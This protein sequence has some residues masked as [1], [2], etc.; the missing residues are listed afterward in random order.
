ML[1]F[2]STGKA[3]SILL[4]ILEVKMEHSLMGLE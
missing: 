1:K 3:M 2:I 4:K